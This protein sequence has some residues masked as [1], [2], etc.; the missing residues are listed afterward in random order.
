MQ[1]LKLSN[2][3]FS[4]HGVPQILMSDNGPQYSSHEFAIFT[5]QYDF[6]HLTSSPHFP[7]WS[8]RMDSTNGEKIIKRQWRFTSSLAML[9]INTN[10]LVQFISFRIAYG[11]KAPN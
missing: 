1:L 6:S 3:F 11:K 2:K 5:K 7:Q 9:L 8:G 10:G 4:G